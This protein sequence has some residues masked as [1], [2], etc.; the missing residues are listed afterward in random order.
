MVNKG[1]KS[2]TPGPICLLLVIKRSQPASR[3]PH[4]PRSGPPSHPFRPTRTATAKPKLKAPRT[5][6]VI[7]S[8]Q[9]EAAERGLTYC[10]VLRTAQE[11]VNIQQLGIDRIR[12]RQTKTR[13]RMLEITGSEKDEKADRL[14]SR[15]R[16]ALADVTTV[17]RPF[18]VRAGADFGSGRNG[19]SRERLTAVVAKAVSIES[20][21]RGPGRSVPAS[22]AR[23]PS[24][25]TARSWRQR[26]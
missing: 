4:R 8:L 2:S 11:K 19:H 15:L 18:K 12:F 22:A 1:K 9:P 24:S 10:S 21:R 20:A 7:L 14:A 16:E 13:A 25:C 3:P 26:S 23:A 17:A 6:T 5:A